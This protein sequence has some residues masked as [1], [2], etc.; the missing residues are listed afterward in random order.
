MQASL[1][2]QFWAH[3][4]TPATHLANAPGRVNLIGEHTD[5]NG[6][7]VLPCAIDFSTLVALRS[8]EDDQV[9][10]LAVNARFATDSIDLG[11]AIA[12]NP[13]QPWA[14]YVRGVLSTLQK[15][16]LHLRGMDMAIVGDI[17]QGTGLSSSASLEVAVIAGV[18]GVH[19]I[20]V[21][22]AQWAQW[23]QQS[24]NQFVGT[25]CGIMD[26]WISATARAEC[27]SLID[28]RSL[29]SQ[30][31]HVPESLQ[32][33]II[34]SQV[35]RGLVGSEYNLRRQQCELAAR[36][37]SQSSLRDVSLEQLLAAEAE[38]DAVVFKRARHILTENARTL[39]MAQALKTDDVPTISRLMAESHASMRDDFEITV[40]AIDHIVA[41]I[42]AIAGDRGGVRMTGG[43]FGGCVVAL[44]P[45]A[46]VD[47]CQAALAEQ[48]R[49]P[50]GTKANVYLPNIGAGAS[51]QALTAQGLAL[52]A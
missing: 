6:G 17:P 44:L 18:C 41:I 51:H 37:F 46:L 13:Q 28:C 20:K 14:D 3:F 2:A 43:G 19:G 47:A 1:L 5:Y 32:L 33:V 4:G 36:H 34:N 15:A 30:H 7:F 23:A 50:N 38:M 35:E 29:E 10:V 52:P 22:P 11:Q 12:H 45:H 40:P 9:K 21:Q 31:C 39:H 16:G 26:M 27:A 8:R 25:Q 49:A 48:Y 42:A 24:E